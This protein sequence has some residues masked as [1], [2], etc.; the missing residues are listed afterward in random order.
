VHPRARWALAAVRMATVWSVA[1]AVGVLLV[2]VFSIVT[3]HAHA[4]PLRY[5]ASGLLLWIPIAFVIGLVFA[6]LITVA[7]R[8][9]ERA[10]LTPAKSATI[11]GLI[12]AIAMR[13][14][15]ARGAD[16]IIA[17]EVTVGVGLIGALIAG[18]VVWMARRAVPEVSLVGAGAPFDQTRPLLADQ[19]IAPMARTGVTD[20]R[21]Q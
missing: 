6:S 4:A 20:R 21:E 19:E 7:E 14:L 12:A 8:W 2:G 16:H 15:F 3:G 1:A 17:W 18:G 10:L 11:G 9:R 5:L 13:A